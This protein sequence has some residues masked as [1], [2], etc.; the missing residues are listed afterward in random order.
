MLSTLT[1]V[2]SLHI[3]DMSIRG[4]P[5]KGKIG[6]DVRIECRAM[7]D[8]THSNHIIW[9]KEGSSHDG[10]QISEINITREI[11]TGELRHRIE[12]EIG[13]AYLKSMLIIKVLGVN[14]TGTYTCRLSEDYFASYHLI[15]D[16]QGEF[17]HMYFY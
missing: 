15:V 11:E 16:P 12:E 2:Y 10:Q 5:T 14:D 3:S 6:R 1:T 8:N 7:G 13:H 9:L 17:F 4:P